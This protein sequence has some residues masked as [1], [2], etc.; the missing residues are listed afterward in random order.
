MTDRL[1]TALE[2]SHEALD[3]AGVF[4]RFVDI[5]SLLYVDPHLLRGS[6][7]P[8]II[9]AADTL[10]SY[11]EDTVLILRRIRVEGDVPWRWAKRRLTF[12][13]NSNIGLGYT[14]A[15]TR[16]AAVGRKTAEGLTRT[17]LAIVQAGIDDPKVFEL[18]GLFEPHVGPDLISD[19]TIHIILPHLLDYT[20]RISKELGIPCQRHSI[21]DR[22]YDLPVSPLTG[23]HLVLLPKDILKDLPVAFCW[24][25]VDTVCGY[26][27]LLRSRMNALIGKT[28]RRAVEDISK[29]KLTKTLIENPDALTDLIQ[30]YRAKRG[31]PYDFVKDLRGETIWLEAGREAAGAFP[32]DL[33]EDAPV[34]AENILPVV[35][36]ICDHFRNLVE[37]NG[38][39]RVFWTDQ[40]QVRHERLAQ[41]LF[42]AVAEAYCTAN[43]LDLSPESNAG[44]GPVDFKLSR[45]NSA[46]VLVEVKWSKNSKLVHGFTTQLEEYAKAE[47]TD[48]M[49]LLVVQVRDSDK[50]I[51]AIKRLEAAA[52]LAGK[53]V[54]EIKVVDGRMKASAS[55]YDD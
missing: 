13:E 39:A 22:P 30:Q 49:I 40:R 24:E 8:E 20:Q 29:R 18:M 35:R 19:M 47:R 34:T 41:L 9:K 32:L 17:A 55:H 46:K 6:K 21:R 5:D 12:P 37:Y 7:A 28:W 23:E 14:V 3:G 2:V 44:R 11:W 15:G 4:D 10:E 27:E 43:N 42:Y 53:P 1:S 16:G 33:S 36:K 54:P 52:I 25:D 38:L 48:S 50:N 51:E 45:G 31:K 26:N